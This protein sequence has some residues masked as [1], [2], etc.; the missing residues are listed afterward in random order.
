MVTRVFIPII[1][2]PDWNE[3]NVRASQLGGVLGVGAPHGV[4]T[5]G[6][7]RAG[8]HQCL[9]ELEEVEVVLVD[10]RADQG[11]V[12]D[13]TTERSACRRFQTLRRRSTAW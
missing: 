3:R 5:L 6:D 10:R 13:L 12:V 11:R 1:V 8:A 7:E 2:D 9:V 4:V